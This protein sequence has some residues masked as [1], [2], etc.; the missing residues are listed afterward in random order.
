MPYAAGITGA[1]H[2][3]ENIALAFASPIAKIRKR[4]GEWIL[5]SS[6]F[7]ACRRV[8]GI[9]AKISPEPM[10]ALAIWC[11]FPDHFPRGGAK[12]ERNRHG[13]FDRAD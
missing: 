1:E 12:M 2:V 3:L 7:E 4:D 10:R 8:R 5:E 6:S 13:E 11:Y 9:L